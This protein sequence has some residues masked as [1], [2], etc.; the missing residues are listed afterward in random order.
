[1]VLTATHSSPFI[2][3]ILAP[4]WILGLGLV[5]ASAP[6]RGLAESA[7]LLLLGLIV[8]PVLMLLAPRGLPN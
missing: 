8:V 1:V 6:A 5:M 4:A 2:R 7:L 3:N